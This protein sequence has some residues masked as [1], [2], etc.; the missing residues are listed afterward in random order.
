MHYFY[1]CFVSFFGILLKILALFHTKIGL[2]VKGRESVFTQL[3]ESITSSDKVLWMHCASLGEFEQ[4]RPVME[5][6]KR[7]FP[8]H[9]IVLTFFSPSG[10]EVQKNYEHADL[11]LY[12]PLDTL[13]NAKTFLKFLRPELAVFVKYEFWPNYLRILQQCKI[14]TILISGIFR[15]NQVFFKPY[16]SWMRAKLESFSHFFVQDEASVALLNSVG[17]ENTTMAGD[18][19]FDRVNT[20]VQR[21]NSLDFIARFKGD[22]KVLVAGSTWKED[23]DLL[24]DYISNSTSDTEKYIIAPHNINKEAIL[25]LKNSLKEKAVLYS[26]REHKTLENYTVFIIDTIG[27]L[28]KIYSY[29]SVAYVGGGYTKSG[30]HNVLEPATFGVPIVIGPNYAKF[31]EVQDLVSRNACLVTNDTISATKTLNELFQNNILRNEKGNSSRSYIEESLGATSKINIY[32]KQLL[33]T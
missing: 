31:K 16:G 3:K 18:T 33:A 1:S 11:I 19:R 15:E 21:D 28:T 24:V 13:S 30:V 25:K 26:E 8:S 5:E 29:A 6:W 17:F 10:F 2:F 4:G 27:L 32:L 20:I 12:L 9:K 22:A 7:E 23:E 14:P